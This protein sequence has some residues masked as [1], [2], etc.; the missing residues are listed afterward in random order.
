MD[1]ALAKKK[2]QRVMLKREGRLQSVKSS[3]TTLRT[4]INI[5]I[6][7]PGT[8]NRHKLMVLDEKWIRD[9]YKQEVKNV[10]RKLDYGL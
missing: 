7:D 3:G 10:T 1:K 9:A 8:G 2:R 6:N 5:F 4:N